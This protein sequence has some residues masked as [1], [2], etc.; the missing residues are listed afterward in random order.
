MK[1]HFVENFIK[2]KFTLDL[3]MKIILKNPL[4]WM[5]LRGRYILMVNRGQAFPTPKSTALRH[6]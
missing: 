6:M 2:N 5:V 3:F 4:Q 1:N